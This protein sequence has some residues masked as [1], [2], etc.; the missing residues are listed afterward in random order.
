MKLNEAIDW[1]D[2]MVPN[3]MDAADKVKFISD[4]DEKV[5]LDIYSRAIGYTGEFNPY[6]SPADDNTELLIPHPYD[7]MYLYYVSAQ[8]DFFNKEIASYNNNM[9]LYTSMWNDYAA[10]YRRNNRPK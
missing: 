6:A 7:S 9:S 5:H 8:I 2:R 3:T 4:V 1:V 10:Y